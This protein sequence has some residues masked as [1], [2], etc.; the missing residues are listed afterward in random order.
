MLNSF[1]HLFIISL[2]C[3]SDFIQEK[4]HFGKKQGSY[5][6][7]AVYDVSMVLSPGMGF[8]IVSFYSI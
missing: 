5:I 8:V 2:S 6:A 3:D 1:A 7:G 4:Y